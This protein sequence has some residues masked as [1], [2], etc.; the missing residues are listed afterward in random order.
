VR[1][2]VRAGDAG[3]DED[4]S[5]G[6]SV[7]GFLVDDELETVGEEGL[8]HEAHLIDGGVGGGARLNVEAV[9]RDVEAS[10]YPG[11][12]FGLESVEVVEPEGHFLRARELVGKDDV[13][14]EG[15][16]GGN[17]E[18]AGGSAAIAGINFGIDVAGVE[19]D[20]AVLRP[21]GLVLPD[22]GDVEGERCRGGGGLG[23]GGGGDEEHEE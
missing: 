22:R 2:K 16:V 5:K 10:A 6:G 4:E 9:R 3:V 14:P 21:A 20:V 1:L 23:D 19:R 18:S 8:H 17:E 12:N 13:L 15:L 11:G 7:A